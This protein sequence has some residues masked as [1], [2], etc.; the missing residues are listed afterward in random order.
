MKKGKIVFT[1]FYTMLKIGLFTFGGGYGMIA[2]LENEFVSKRKWLSKE[3]FL[4]MI[5]I[6]ESS[7]GPIAINSSTY[8]G[9]KMAKFWGSLAATVAVCIPSFV[10]I[11]VISLF[12]DAFLSFEYVAYAFRGIQVG[13]AF[14][15]FTAGLKM[16]KD[17]K[18]KPLPI[19]ILS[20]TAILMICFALFAVKFSSIYYILISGVVGL[21]S[22]HLCNIIAKRKLAKQTQN[23][24]VENSKLNQD[25]ITENK[26]TLFSI[27]KEIEND[28]EK[29]EALFERLD[30][31]ETLP[32]TEPKAEEPKPEIRNAEV[33]KQNE[34]KI[35]TK[36][37]PKKKEGKK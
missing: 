11:F 10:I 15:I 16:L 7:P 6:A 2:L 9:Y 14:L 37:P 13:V 33:K 4:D 8:I 29:I 25:K 31:V 3:E 36:K 28:S 34:K 21:F 23:M 22:Y 27:S 30:E 32:K 17:I 35:S 20:V 1:L 12:L 26:E 5:A 18:R 24:Q 19:I